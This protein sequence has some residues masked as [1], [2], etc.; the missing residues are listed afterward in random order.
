MT[1]IILRTAARYLMP[2]LFLFSIFVLFRG[3]N[4]PGGGFSGGLLAATGFAL[5]LFAA[6]AK[7]ARK[8]V[9]ID[10]HLI[11]GSG[12]LL[13]LGSGLPALFQGKGFMTS[14]WGQLGETAVGTPLLFDVGVYLVVLGSSLMIILTLGE[15]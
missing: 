7:E 10:P 8:A 13:A 15:E 9:H 12:L 11:M 5:Y 2:L 3:H 14:L 1:S 6:D 4:L